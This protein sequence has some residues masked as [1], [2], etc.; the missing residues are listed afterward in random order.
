MLLTG[1]W[2]KAGVYTVEEFDPDPF[3][4]ALDQYGLPRKESHSPVLV[5]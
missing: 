5:D 2:K 4:K 1:E 3:L